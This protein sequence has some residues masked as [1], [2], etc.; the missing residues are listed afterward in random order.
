MKRQWTNEELVEHW[1]LSPKELDLIGDSKT[2]HNLLGAA[3]LLKYFQHEG[4]FPSQKQDVPPS[5]SCIW[6]SS[7]ASS[8]KRSFLT[9]GK[10]AGE[11]STNQLEDQELAMLALHLL[12]ISLVFIQNLMIQE[13]LTEPAWMNKMTKE[14]L[15]GLTPL[16][17]SNVNPYGLIRLNMAERLTIERAESV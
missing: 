2:D 15:R 8:R 16:I 17:Y 6:P 5:S 3:C 10:D 9:I 12:Q 1:T 14:D 11:F 4:Q 13:V 7:W